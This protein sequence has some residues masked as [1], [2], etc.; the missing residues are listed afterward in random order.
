MKYWRHYTFE[1]RFSIL[2]IL[3]DGSVPIKYGLRLNSDSRYSDFKKELS[4]LCNLHPSLMLV[5]ELY[6]SQIR[7]ALMDN[8][9]LKVSSATDLFVY[10]IPKGDLWRARTSSE[11]GMTIENGLKDIQRNPGKSQC[12]ITLFHAIHNRPIS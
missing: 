8:H 10:E 9:R 1:F 3:L 5:C 4:T 6:N 2:V 11:L 12:I 7:C